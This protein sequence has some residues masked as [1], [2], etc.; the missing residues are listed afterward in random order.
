MRAGMRRWTQRAA[1]CLCALMVTAASIGEAQ[2]SSI[3]GVVTDQATGQPLEAAR[4]VLMG[5]DRIVGTNQ[6]GRYLFRNIAPGSY[7][8]RVLRLGYA[9]LTDSAHVAPG[10][11]TAH[12]GRDLV[13]G[14]AVPDVGDAGHD[15]PPGPAARRA[16]R[17]DPGRDRVRLQPDRGPPIPRDRLTWRRTR[18][19]PVAQFVTLLVTC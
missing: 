15:P 14:D 8:V 3:G 19:L 9:P 1:H 12:L 17:R 11:A 10:D 6:E 13:G 5:I 7:G 2:Q 18:P 4:V 16:H